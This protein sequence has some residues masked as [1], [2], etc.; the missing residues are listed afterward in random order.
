MDDDPRRHPLAADPPTGNEVYN[1]EKARYVDGD[2]VYLACVVNSFLSHYDWSG[3]NPATTLFGQPGVTDA[4]VT[5]VLDEAA[6]VYDVRQQQYLGYG[7]RINASQPVLEG[8]V[9]ALLPYQVTGLNVD[10][11]SFDDKQR[12]SLTV[13]VQADAGAPGRHV[14]R[15][16]VFDPT[17]DPMHH[18]TRTLVAP[19][20][21]FSGIIPFAVDEDLVGGLIR[22]TDVATGAQV[23]VNITTELLEPAL[24]TSEPPADGTLPKTQSTLMLLTFSGT[25]AL[26]GG[27]ALSV[28]PLGGGADVGASFDYSIEPDGVTLKAVEQGVVLTNQTWYQVTPAAGLD[29]RPFTLDVCTLIGDCNGNGRVTTA[30]YSCVKLAMGQRDHV[31]EDLNGSGRVTTADYLVVKDHMGDRAPVAPADGRVYVDR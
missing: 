18:L 28:V 3:Q 9:F 2:I 20:G 16:E 1:F 7:T 14:L 19:D 4:D 29:V 17:S 24:L 25:I 21:L 23:E 15:L 13:S 31:R 6:H 5:L 10:S 27:P 26:P 8:G 12:A 11:I 22:L 30:D